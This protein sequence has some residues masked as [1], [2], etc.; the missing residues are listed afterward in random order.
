VPDAAKIAQLLQLTVVL[1]SPVRPPPN[2]TVQVS[3]ALDSARMNNVMQ[4]LVLVVVVI[5]Q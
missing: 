1:A 4:Y 5:H 3:P 2:W